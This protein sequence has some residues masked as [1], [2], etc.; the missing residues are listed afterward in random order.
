MRDSRSLNITVKDLKQVRT[1]AGQNGTVSHQL[2]TTHLERGSKNQKLVQ[3]VEVT[4]INS[5][6]Y[7]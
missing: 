5:S 7:E 1:A 4:N 6:F 3:F 2:V